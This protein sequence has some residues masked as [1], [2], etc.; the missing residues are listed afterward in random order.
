MDKGR[1]VDFFV[2]SGSEN[3]AVDMCSS[4]KSQTG[5]EASGSAKQRPEIQKRRAAHTDIVLTRIVKS[6]NVAMGAVQ[7][8]P[9]VDTACCTAR[10]H[11]Q[12][13]VRVV[14]GQ[15]PLYHEGLDVHVGGAN[16]QEGVLQ[17]RRGH[18]T[19]C[20]DVGYVQLI[21]AL[22][23]LGS[24]DMERHHLHLV[25]SASCTGA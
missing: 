2:P 22:A 6:W 8:T 7:Q 19:V 25:Q 3:T 18:L 12:I 20:L 13:P 21:A 1:G 10:A 5:H 23:V 4:E 14:E 17:S 16:L 15:F 9:I 24:A 11:R